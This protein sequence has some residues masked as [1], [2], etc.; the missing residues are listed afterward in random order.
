MCRFDNLSVKSTYRYIKEKFMGHSDSDR[1]SFQER[2]YVH[3]LFGKHISYAQLRYLRTGH[4]DVHEYNR[5]G[6]AFTEGV[7]GKQF[8][9]CFGSAGCFNVG[10]GNETIRDVLSDAIDTYDMGS[11][12]LLSEEKIRFAVKLASICPG[13]LNKVVLCATGS[14]ACAAAIKLARGA[15]KREDIISTI[16]GYHGLQGFSLSANGKEYFKELFYP[17]MPGFHNV[18]YND[19]EAVKRIASNDVAAILLELVQGEG[20]IHP[21]T[22]AYIKGLRKICDEYGIMLIFDEVQTGY[23]RTGSMWASEQYGVIPDIMMTAKSAGGGVYVNAA[24]VY[25]EIEPLVSYVEA[26]P[27]F[28]ISPSGGTDLACIVNDAVIDYIQ[29]NEVLENVA[30]TGRRFREGLEEIAKKNRFLI[31]EIRG[32]GL[33]LGI[34]YKY[35]F[36]AAIMCDCLAKRGLWATY[37]TNSPHVMRFMVSPAISINEIDE[38]LRRIKAAVNEL[39]IY[40]LLL[41]PL[42]WLPIIGKIIADVK[43]E[44]KFGNWIRDIEDL[45]IRIKNKRK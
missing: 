42:Y 25:R 31:K 12:L 28:H 2:D 43:N 6:S 7:S 20:G 15:T 44:I 24:I 18:P 13:D 19:L 30:A 16:K 4:M 26:N 21:A 33:M 10:R 1:M 39:R 11:H 9:D 45:F 32:A 34:E 38:V 35:E 3:D 8:Y 5:K 41:L 14:D 23:G 37:S 29:N 36:I 17:L 22:T 27:Y 40:A